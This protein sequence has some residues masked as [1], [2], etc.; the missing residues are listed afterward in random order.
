MPVRVV[1]VGVEVEDILKN[2]KD[3]AW[4]KVSI[5]FCGGTHVKTTGDIK[6]LV[7]IEESGIAKGIRR[8]IAVTGNDAHEVQRVADDFGER[9]SQLESKDHSAQK[10]QDTKT[11]SVELNGLAISAIRKTAFRKQFEKIV[12]DNL[13]HQKKRQNEEKKKGIE[14]LDSYFE[15]NKDASGGVIRL[16]IGGSSKA[17]NDV[18]KQITKSQKNKTVYI[19]A[20]EDDG[21]GRVQH[22]CV[23]SPVGQ[24]SHI[25]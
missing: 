10:E 19:F 15:Q 12:K 6:D 25:A 13:E 20:A 7:I 21:S 9:L 1:S 4:Q 24:K 18:L 16:P 14:A 8:M 2:P 3:P 11:I 17:F 5:E 22:A 23:V